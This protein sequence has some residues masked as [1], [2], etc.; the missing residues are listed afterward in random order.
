MSSTSSSGISSS[1]TTRMA[2][3][4]SGFDTETL[5]KNMA[6][7]TKNKINTKKQKVQTLYWK[8][9]SYRSIISKVSDFQTKYLNIESSSSVRANA[10][11]KKFSATSSNDKVTCSASSTATEAT[12]TLKSS[13]VA[14]SAKITSGDNA[15]TSNGIGLDF[16]EAVDGTEYK[17]KVTLDGA[18]KTVTFNGGADADTTKQ[19][20]LDAVNDT[21]SSDLGTTYKFK[22][23]DDNE[24]V[25]ADATDGELTTSDGITHK[26]GVGYCTALGLNNDTSNIIS[27]NTTL[28]SIKFATEMTTDDSDGKYKF[29]IND[30]DFEFTK[31][32]SVY[33]MM[34]EINNSSAN[35]KMS[36]NSFAQ[37]FKIESKD[38]GVGSKLD[39]EQTSGNLLNAIMNTDSLDVTAGKNSTLTF[40]ADDGADITL[41]NSLN[42][43]NIDGTSI[44]VQKL[45][46]FSVDN[47]DD[48]ITITTEKDNSAVVE[49][50]KSFIEAY[51]SLLSDLNSMVDTARPK[52]NN[53]YYDPLTEEQEDEMD[54][55]EID[56]WNENAKT[57]LLYHDT[58]ISTLIS[59]L[60]TTMTESLNGFS[61]SDLG[62]SYSK[63]YADKGK[64]ILDEDKL[65]RCIEAH[66]DTA[67]DFFTNLD[68]GLAGKL[69]TVIDKAIS[70]TSKSY[71]Y[72]TQIAGIESTNS[73]KTNRIYLQ[74]DSYQT[75]ID[76]LQDSYEDEQERYWSKFTT[77]ETYIN[78]MNSQ[79]SIFSSSTE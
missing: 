64:L 63:V 68:S 14:T 29:T 28:G 21:F 69:D 76:T 73:E 79:S 30:V 44:N 11:M 60:R 48:E 51:N 18:V 23:N 41:T 15:I 47:G 22:V 55:D 67:A 3:L 49:T 57:G 36:F 66:G 10:V 16:D 7:A 27:G 42:I 43:Y 32:T 58:Y 39:I 56:S 53:S 2:G 54:Q 78:N 6:A 45:G 71:G 9:E 34:S 25:F 59:N 72:L 46:E 65:A 50:V 38:T 35:V 77:L 70:N 1:N 12:Y 33:T 8:Q 40:S 24:L 20:F 17:V 5:V 74:I 75:I 37:S 52:D 61:L 4:I 19:N 31:D 62:L 26:F 13:T